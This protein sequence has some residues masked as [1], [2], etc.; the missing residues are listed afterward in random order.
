MPRSSK[1]TPFKTEVLSAPPKR[2]VDAIV[3]S[4]QNFTID[5]EKRTESRWKNQGWQ[6]VIWNYFDVVPEFHYACTWVGN[7]LSQARL[8]PMDADGKEITSG[9]AFDAMEEFFDGPEGQREFLRNSGIHLTA[10]GDQMT[11]GADGP[12]ELD[13]TDWLVAAT[14]ETRKD[15]TDSWKVNDEVFGGN[16]LVIRMWRPHPRN[17]QY[18]DCPARAC[19]P[20]LAELDG[21]TKRVAAQVDSRLASAGILALPNEITF[22]S[23]QTQGAD[24]KTSSSNSGE[25]FVKNFI[26][27]MAT[28]IQDPESAAALVPIVLQMP[29]EYVD[30]IKLV[31]LASTLDKEAKDLRDESIRRLAL[32]MDMPPEV[33]EGTADMNHWSSWQVEEA[34]IKTHSEPLLA[35]IASA[36]LTGFLRP[37]LVGT[38]VAP[39][40]VFVGV[41]DTKLRLRPNRS[42][43]SVE[44]Y[45]RGLLKAEVVLKENGFDPENDAMDAE[46]LQKFL[47]IAIAKGS[48]TPDQVAAANRA[49]GVNIPLEVG[50]ADQDTR[51]E[52]PRPSLAEHPVRELPPLSNGNID[53][54]NSALIAGAG[55]AVHRAL[56]RAGNKLRG[57]AKIHRAETAADE[58]LAVK[59]Q[60][61]EISDLLDDAWSD[62]VVKFARELDVPAANLVA[63]LDGYTRTL[64]LTQTE[65]SP[66]TFREYLSRRRAA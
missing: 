6:K 14:S 11:I 13:G 21:L 42:K 28:G 26:H 3:A 25:E 31:S 64:I 61:T 1:S 15:A 33:L 19:M 8:Y 44:L 48:A 52:R 62:G 45:D 54:N 38:S 18:S 36:V 41:D 7:M 50:P 17:R 29:G 10:T 37:A 66:A 35:I 5:P 65:H 47:T 20:I 34:A 39:E 40:D 51:E 22:S 49:L 27:T 59:L 46:E 53:G 58:Y 2:R 24:G 63:V 16:P 4:A 32:G 30:K 57:K 60:E 56:E 12:N 23:T 55:L 43:E 9:P